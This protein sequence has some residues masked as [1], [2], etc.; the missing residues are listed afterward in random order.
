MTMKHKILARRANSIPLF[1]LFLLATFQLT[2]CA[3]NAVTGERNLQF[4]GEDWEQKIGAQMYAPMK[5]SQGGDLT[6]DPQLTAYVQSVGNRLANQARR[7]DQL[8]FEF[9]VLNDSSP[10]AWALPGGKIVVNRGLLT[11]LKSEAELA[12]VLGHEIVHA[13]AAH[14]AQSQSKGMLTQV[15]TLVGMVVIG[16]QVDNP[17]AREVA[18]I[19]PQLGAQLLTQKYGRDAERESDE[20]GMRYMSE[21]GYD[22]QGAVELQKTFLKL[23]EGRNSDWMSGLFASHPPSAERLQNNIKTAQSLP[24]EGETGSARY[25]EKIAYQIRVKPAYDAYDE[26]NKALS[27]DNTRDAQ[28]KISQ[29]L[30]VV[31]EESL[32]LALQG[33]IHAM[34]DKTQPAMSSYS[35]AIAANDGLFYGYLRR[36]QLEYKRSESNKARADLEKSLSLLPTSEAHYLLGLLDKNSRQ[37]DKAIQHFQVA[38]QS[39]SAS[40]QNARRE[41]IQLD[42]PKNPSQY[43]ASRAM[44][45]KNNQVWATVGNQTGVAIKD[46]EITFVWLDENNQTRQGK[47][48]YRGPLLSGKQDSIKLGIQLTNPGELSQ[49]VK[50]QVTSAQMA[51]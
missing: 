45:D 11:E 38:A 6:V 26:A 39:Q 50:V 48:V 28:K 44:A 31:P 4:Y 8:N 7:K 24:A 43:V 32:F 35:Q 9:S 37:M 15:G 5:Q 23:S 20:Y 36:G 1:A 18:M 34:N 47:T 2:G 40:G 14:S 51:E 13:D 21:A 46:I 12:A 16:T 22:P 3:V 49:R 41:L 17:A 30:A 27:E 33:D 19:V 42:L 29:A 25:L 10:N